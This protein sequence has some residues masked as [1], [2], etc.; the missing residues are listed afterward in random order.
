[1]APR[2][3]SNPAAPRA[4]LIGDFFSYHGWLAPGVRLF[5][6][7]GF[8]AKALCISMAFVAPLLMVLSYLWQA[9]SA[10]VGGARMERQGVVAIGAA[11]GVVQA[12]RAW[13]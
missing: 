8:P 7:L 10:Q 5:R 9:S 13:R 1:M 3:A 4:G 6:D 12:A 2:H 11:V